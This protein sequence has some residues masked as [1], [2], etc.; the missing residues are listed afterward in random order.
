MFARKKIKNDTTKY[1]RMMLI[2]IVVFLFFLSSR[3]IFNAP[4]EDEDTPLRTPVE[5]SNMTIEI[6]SKEFYMDT[7]L[8]QID[9]I[10]NESG[11]G[12]PADLD[13]E[14]K[15]KTNT[16]EQYKKELTQITDQYYV[17]FVHDLPQKWKSVSLDLYNKREAEN[18]I[19]LDEK[20]YVS[21]TETDKKEVFI[22]RKIEFYEVK[23]IN[24]LIEDAD[25]IIQ[26][27]QEKK[28]ETMKKITQMERRIESIQ[29]E[30]TYKTEA[31]KAEEKQTIASLQSQI[32]TLN[33]EKEEADEGIKEQEE[34]I[35][36]L[37]TRK[38]D[39]TN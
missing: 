7:N 28:I 3:I 10:V 35:K 22:Q 6:V 21:N 30:F 9:L 1:K 15:E 26:N 18:T 4:S 13:V 33:R 32:E 25:K 19:N 23:F 39:L 14:V 11:N 5:R 29:E 38:N 20:L 34:R 8:L 16:K 24:L 17:L 37:T 27:E 12:I 31:E 36:N 2:I